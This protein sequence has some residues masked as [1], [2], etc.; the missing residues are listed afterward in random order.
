MSHYQ[1]ILVA[2]DVFD[3]YKALVSA[4]K[5]F[6][7]RFGANLEFAYVLPNVV[8]NIPYA[9]DIQGDIKSDAS[10][11]LDELKACAKVANDAVHMLHGNPKHE[12]SA[13]A[14]R[15]KSDLVIVGSHGKHGLELLLGSTANG[16]LHTAKCDV[17]TIRLND[18]EEHIVSGNYKHILLA[19]DLEKDSKVVCNAAKTLQDAFKAKLH[20]SHVVPNTTAT[21]IAYYPNIE[22]ELRND[23]AKKMVKLA[24]K[25]GIEPGHIETVIGLPKHAIESAAEDSKA[26]LI[27]IGS[28]GRSGIS[29]ALLG[30]TAN[31]V[32][33]AAD[34]D[35]L[36]VRI[37]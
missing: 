23:A 2:I 30:S 18:K 17:L 4:A 12:I 28:H 26:E 20:A 24:E 34:Q 6:A 36:V 1:S 13:L 11:K 5:A 32:L 22:E 10:K 27:V 29:A 7:K 25:Y 21:A 37:K 19:T 33:H 35:V 15:L 3:E 9:Y 14:E 8:T 31:A 16:I